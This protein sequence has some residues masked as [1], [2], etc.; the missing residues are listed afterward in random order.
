MRVWFI[1]YLF[2]GEWYIATS[3]DY[4]FFR[5]FEEAREYIVRY[6]DSLPRNLELRVSSYSRD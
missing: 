3:Y 6:P 1:E 5:S 2:D 4:N